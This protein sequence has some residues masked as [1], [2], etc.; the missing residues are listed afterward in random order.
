MN[1]LSSLNAGA[2]GLRGDRAT[3]VVLAAAV[4]TVAYISWRPFEILFTLS[5][6]LFCLGFVLL[7]R[8]GRV[9][10]SPFGNLTGP[11]LLCTV[12]MLGGLFL[13]SVV[14]GDPV[15]WLI[16]SLQ[17]A[18][19]LV[20][21]PLM[22]VSR[23]PARGSMLLIA[24]VAGIAA[25]Q[26]FGAGVYFLYPGD[27]MQIAD[28]F[29][30]AFISAA[31][32]LGAF[33]GD[34]NWNAAMCAMA[35][36]STL[37]L[38]VSRR[39]G[40]LVATLLAALLSVGIL[41]SG[42]FTGFLSAVTSLLIVG[43]AAGVRRGIRY[44]M[45][46][47]IVILLYLLSG[48]PLPQAFSKRV[49]P[50]LAEAEISEAGTFVGRWQLIEEAWSM[51][52][53]TLVV[54]LG[55]DQYRVV[56]VQQAPVHNIF[57]LLWTEGGLFALL[58]WLGLMAILGGITAVALG[59]DRLTGGLAASILMVFLIQSTASPHMYAR[60]WVVPLLIVAGLALQAGR[61]RPRPFPTTMHRKAG[62]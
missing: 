44:A 41:L 31:R 36:P 27:W 40:V 61:S 33:L 57:L 50:A 29:G 52:D 5:D 21:L 3:G 16:V 62:Q 46:G 35:L 20:L 26:A 22:L 39:I 14:N 48:A 18:F 32:R 15:R 2:L 4:F 12:V 7:L 60:M 47:G 54:G 42:S 10:L 8:S 13:G 24:F 34:A 6:A 38:L 53:R 25:M 1:A 9:P 45:G 49:A 43:M 30:H 17:Y 28:V 23:D 56:S 37:F 58:G 11:W 59:R 19:S 55:V 51:T